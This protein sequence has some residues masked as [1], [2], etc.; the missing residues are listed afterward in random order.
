[1]RRLVALI[2]A[3]SLLA[4][5]GTAAAGKRGGPPPFPQFGGTWSHAEINVTIKH[6]PHTLILDRGRILQSSSAQ[7]TLR[8]SD[9]TTQIVPVGPSTKFTGVRVRTSSPLRRA[10][11]AETMRIDGGNAV[12]VRVTLRP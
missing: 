3:L 2:A 4:F 10:L 11:Y 1:M 7:L 5:A 12:R 8:E 6:Q 9:G